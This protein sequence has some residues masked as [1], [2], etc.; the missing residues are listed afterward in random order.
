MLTGLKEFMN[1]GTVSLR[2]LPNNGMIIRKTLCHF[3]HL[4]RKADTNGVVDFLTNKGVFSSLFIS[5]H[6]VSPDA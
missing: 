4:C 3:F 6:F 5:I 2:G 1:S